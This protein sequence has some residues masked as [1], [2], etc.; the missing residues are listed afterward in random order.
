VNIKVTRTFAIDQATDS[1]GR[2]WAGWDENAT[3]QVNWDHNRGRHTFG[4]RVDQERY[5]TI[6]YDGRIRLVV[7]LTGRKEETNPK[8]GARKKW[9]LEGRVLREDDP[10]RQ[11][12]LELPA[13]TGRNTIE[14]IEDPDGAITARN[15]FLL[16][17]NPAR[18]EIDPDYMAEWVEAT[19]TGHSVEGRWS[20]GSTTK[21]IGPGDRAFLLR[22][23]VAGRGIFASGTFIS[24]VFQAEHWDGEGGL[25]NYADVSWDTALDPDDLLPI[26]TLF[27]ELQE[28]QWE[29]QASGSQIKAAVVGRLEELWADHVRSVR[30]AALPPTT[31]GR[32]LG[33]GQGRRLDAKL[34]KEIED[35]AQER[36]MSF[37]RDDD[38]NVEDLRIGNPFDARATK[39]E[40]TLYLEAKGTVT[41]GERVIV[42]RGEIAWARAHPGEC[43]IGILSDITLKDDGSVDPNS[44]ILRQYRWEPE[45]DDLVPLDYDFYPPTDALISE[46]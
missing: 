45:D 38:W 13:P 23:G 11:A 44:G 19:A 22:Q 10:I 34:R 33:A 42:T 16:T 21:K 41:S 37:Y 36:L 8:G 12:F 28:G 18:W 27:A 6:S 1:M 43:V 7:E 26:E 2:T 31:P 39:E 35:L 24:D 15:A 14:Y 4:S 40:E 3:D 29:P 5:A 32:K 20:T 25:A 9:S 17:N 30:D 46:N